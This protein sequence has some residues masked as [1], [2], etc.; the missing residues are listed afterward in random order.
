[1]T[2]RSRTFVIM[3]VS[4]ACVSCASQPTGPTVGVRPPTRFLSGQQGDRPQNLRPDLTA[5]NGSSIGPVVVFSIHLE[6]AT[7]PSFTPWLITNAVAEGKTGFP[8]L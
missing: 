4:S 6:S 8:T 3:L 7:T 5:T 1:M 2:P